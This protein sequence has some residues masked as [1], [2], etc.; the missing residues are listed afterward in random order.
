MHYKISVFAKPFQFVAVLVLSFTLCFK[1]VEDAEVR[2]IF[3]TFCANIIYERVLVIVVSFYLIVK[4]AS[5][6]FENWI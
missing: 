2:P 1:C 6:Q 3:G 5:I 4:C